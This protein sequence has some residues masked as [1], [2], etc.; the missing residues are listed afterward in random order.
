MNADD[1]LH[2]PAAPPDA[3]WETVRDLIAIL[4]RP[5]KATRLLNELE[6]RMADVK[7]A[8]AKLA[9]AREAHDQKVARDTALIEEKA[10]RLRSKEIS[11]MGRESMAERTLARETADRLNRARPLSEA[12]TISQEPA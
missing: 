12:A 7:Q 3:A 9:A 5:P 4:A 1:P 10:G 2:A 8:E 11:L 6:R